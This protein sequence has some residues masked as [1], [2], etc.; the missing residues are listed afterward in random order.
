MDKKKA[1][2][3]T[4]F[5]DES[6]RIDDNSNISQTALEESNDMGDPLIPGIGI[7]GENFEDS[8]K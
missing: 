5:V 8:S 4:N 2:I 1:N 3:Q 7:E 6:F